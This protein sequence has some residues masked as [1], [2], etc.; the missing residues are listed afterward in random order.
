MRMRIAAGLVAVAAGVAALTTG[1]AAAQPKATQPKGT[2]PKADGP[3]PK[4][5]YAHDL[6]VRPGGDKDWVKA[7]KVGVEWFKYETPGGD[8]KPGTPF[9]LAVTDGGSVGV[10]PAGVVGADKTSKWVS[11]N[12]LKVR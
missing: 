10:F 5:L 9:P 6:K 4:Y 1:P 7:T 11:G 3:A 12:D 2:P 8:G